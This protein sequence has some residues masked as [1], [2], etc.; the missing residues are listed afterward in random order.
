MHKPTV[1][2]LEIKAAGDTTWHR[3]RLEDGRCDKF[4]CRGNHDVV[5]L[6]PACHRAA[7]VA[8]LDRDKPRLLLSCAKCGRELAALALDPTRS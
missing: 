6:E 2:T 3:L 4:D 1:G 5:T 8:M 7:V